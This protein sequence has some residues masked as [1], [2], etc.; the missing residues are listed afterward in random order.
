V[1]ARL[2]I[3]LLVGAA[4]LVAAGATVAATVLSRDEPEREAAARPA[5]APV[6][7][8]DLG[9]RVDPEARAL[10][11]ASSLYARGR[12]AEAGRV[13]ARYDSLDARVGA[14]LS[15]WPRGTVARLR[16]LG[17]ARPESALVRLHLGIANAWAGQPQA[18]VAE[19][20][21]AGRVEP[22]SLSAIRADDFLHPRSPRGVPVF[23]PS[24]ESRAKLEGLS[25]DRQLGVLRRR[26]RSGGVLDKL[27]YGSALQ[28]L[29][30]PVSA[31]QEF[32]A[33]ARL[34]PSD[35]E[36]RVAVAVARFRK[37]A[38][39]PAFSRLGPLAGRYP[40][41]QTVRFHLGLLLLWLGEVEDARR[42]LERARTLD[43]VSRLGTEASRFLDRLEGVG[44][45]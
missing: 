38:P 27:V 6:L 42:Q 21:A 3:W 9:V 41:S 10:R 43:P 44:T 34:A 37:G 20:R 12:R 35:P 32:A 7:L 45:D 39:A 31:E 11:R 29:G 5:G 28:R 33:A 26:A 25:P 17:E 2:R 18:A 40:S 19:F 30:K 23:V 24:A 36:P 15:A 4:A 13:F 16:R 8:L 1:S 22:D 14:A